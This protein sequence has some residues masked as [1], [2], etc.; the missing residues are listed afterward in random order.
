MTGDQEAAGG[1]HERY[2]NKGELY[3]KGEMFNYNETDYADFTCPIPSHFY[4]FYFF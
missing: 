2:S 1:C 3:I 4:F